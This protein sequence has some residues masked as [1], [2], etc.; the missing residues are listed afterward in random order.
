MSENEINEWNASIERDKKLAAARE[1]R[2][3]NG[4]I[5]KLK[6]ATFVMTSVRLMNLKADAP[7]A[8]DVL[9]NLGAIQN[10]PR[11]GTS[12]V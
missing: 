11:G 4:L 1:E 8:W 6:L 7:S 3:L 5:V 9:V 12:R 10:A 2:R